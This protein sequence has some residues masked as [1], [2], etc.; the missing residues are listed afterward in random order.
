MSPERSNIRALVEGVKLCCS[1][2]MA[3]CPGCPTSPLDVGSGTGSGES[4][5]MLL[6]GDNGEFIGS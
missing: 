6:R 2:Y 4:W 3:G 5:Y 1:M